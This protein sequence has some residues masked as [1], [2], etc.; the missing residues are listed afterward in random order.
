MFNLLNAQQFSHHLLRTC[1]KEGDT[2]L[3]G[4]AGNGHDTVLLGRLVGDTGT[5][6]ACDCQ[7]TA[8]ERTA[9]LL[10]EHQ[11][12][13]RV[14]LIHGS[15]AHLAQQLPKDVQLQAAIFNLG[16]LPGGNK[17]LVTKADSTLPALNFVLQHLAPNGLLLVVVYTGHEGGAEEADAVTAAVSQLDQRAY[18]VLHYRFVN[19]ANHPPFLYAVQRRTANKRTP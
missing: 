13:Q 17:H 3:D 4:T 11:L 6:W 10:H 5:V 7:Q 12:Q 2:V 8:I 9:A 1:V 19:Q 16:Y 14:R 18:T 15:H